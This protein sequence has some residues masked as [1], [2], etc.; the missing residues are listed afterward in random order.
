MIVMVSIKKVSLST[1]GFSREKS[2][3]DVFKYSVFI[4]ISQEVREKSLSQLEALIY[5]LL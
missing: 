5:A 1:L 2:L 3:S 4:A